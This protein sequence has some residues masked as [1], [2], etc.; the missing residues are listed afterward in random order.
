LRPRLS[1]AAHKTIW[2]AY[3]H[4]KPTAAFDLAPDFPIILRRP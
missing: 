1:A 2:E 3:Q 4:G